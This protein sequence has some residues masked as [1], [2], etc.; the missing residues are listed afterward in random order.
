MT[1]PRA[2]SDHRLIRNS[3][4]AWQPHIQNQLELLDTFWRLAAV[5]QRYTQTHAHHPSDNGQPKCVREIFGEEF[6]L[7]QITV[8]YI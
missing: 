6:A 8:D 1:C 7:V 4:P 3:C 2:D 5:D